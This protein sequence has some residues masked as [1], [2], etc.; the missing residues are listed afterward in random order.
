VDWGRHPYTTLARLHSSPDAPLV[1]L[2]WYQTELPFIEGETIIN[3][4]YYNDAQEQVKPVGER[5][6]WES[7]RVYNGQWTTPTGLFGGHICHRDWFRTGEPWP[8]SL[9]DTVYTASGVPLCCCVDTYLVLA[10][11]LATCVMDPG[12]PCH[13]WGGPGPITGKLWVVSAPFP[14][15]L[16]RWRVLRVRN[17][18]PT[19]Y[20]WVCSEEWNGRGLS[21]VFELS[22][23]G[24]P[25]APVPLLQVQEVV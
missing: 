20:T 10:N 24:D 13:R 5:P 23:V 14:P 19:F 4:T 3:Q 7:P 21:P 22:P 12:N 15:S 6:E 11:E 2:R 8:T 16:P 1:Q 18:L 25:G 9:P 17:G